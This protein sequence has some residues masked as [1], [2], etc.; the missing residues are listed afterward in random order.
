MK[1]IFL[2]T[3]YIAIIVLTMVSCND[4]G[5]LICMDKVWY[6]DIDGDGKGDRTYYIYSCK[7][8]PKG[9]V[10]NSDDFCDND[11]NC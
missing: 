11:P 3:A 1:K 9:F 5:D 10:S 6:R 4:E 2:L 7:V 8:Q